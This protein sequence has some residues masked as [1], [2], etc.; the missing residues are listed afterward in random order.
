MLNWGLLTTFRPGI[1][2]FSQMLADGS[3]NFK[4][5]YIGFI[6]ALHELKTI[7]FLEF[8]HDA[9]FFYKWVLESVQTI[10]LLLIAV[11][12]ME[13]YFLP[14]VAI[15]GLMILS[16]LLREILIVFYAYNTYLVKLVHS[17][18]ICIVVLLAV[19]YVITSNVFPFAAE[20]TQ[21]GFCEFALFYWI[22]ITPIFNLQR[23]QNDAS[24]ILWVQ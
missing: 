17:I 13:N 23:I 15:A 14:H 12:D 9:I 18:S 10:C 3:V 1:P 4:I 16:S 7:T 6:F 21:W 20:T 19:T 5:A 2:S 11:V 8:P 24:Q 22:G